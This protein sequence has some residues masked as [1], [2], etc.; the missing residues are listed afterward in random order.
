MSA[1]HDGGSGFH[2]LSFKLGRNTEGLENLNRLFEQHC[3]DDD[4]RH[5]ENVELLKANNEAIDNLSR[6]LAP[7]AANYKMTKRR[8]A[9]VASLG[10]SVLVGLSWAAEVLVKWAFGW[11]LK[12]KF[13]G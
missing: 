3:E 1:N 4:R 6:A 5:G 12:I 11:L 2:E 7:I 13:G 9:L 10:F 8:L